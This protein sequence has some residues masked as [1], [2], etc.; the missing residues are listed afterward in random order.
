MY[1]N[2]VSRA[3]E[4]YSSAEANPRSAP[5]SD[6]DPQSVAQFN[7]Q[8]G[9]TGSTD[10]AADAQSAAGAD[11]SGIQAL[12]EQLVQ[13][14]QQLLQ[15]LGGQSDTGSGAES[16]SGSNSSAGAPAAQ[17][18]ESGKPRGGSVSDGEGTG[19]RSALGNS[20]IPPPVDNLQ[21]VQLGGKTLTVGGDGTGTASASEVSQTAA[22]I[23]NLYA[24]SPSFK[25]MID[26]SPH[27]TLEVSVGRRADNTSWGGGGSVYMNLNNIAPGNSDTFQE[28]L[29]HEFAHAA[30]DMRH[31]SEQ[32]A[33]QDQI[34]AEA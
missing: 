20:N 10:R 17:A 1:L 4:Q 11:Q 27:Q 18:G 28:L 23:Q 22:S 5:P 24:N 16:A 2:S 31:G 14:L 19:V 29:A 6:A 34:A 7:Q 30:V 21:S 13:L 26:S 3:Q 12:L 15:A 9:Q 25:Q 8:I 33:L 32:E